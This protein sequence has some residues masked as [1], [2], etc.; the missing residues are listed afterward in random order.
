MNRRMNHF[1]IAFSPI[2][3]WV[4]S[5]FSVCMLSFSIATVCFFVGIA[6][7][8]TTSFC[9]SFSWPLMEFAQLV[10]SKNFVHFFLKNNG[11]NRLRPQSL[12]RPLVKLLILSHPLGASIV[13]PCLSFLLLWALLFVLFLPLP[14]QTKGPILVPTLMLYALLLDNFQLCPARNYWAIS[15][16]YS[17]GLAA[18]NEFHLESAVV[19]T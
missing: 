1:T 11:P 3:S 6:L 12:T 13:F 16:L 15:L 7:T 8:F 14:P 5:S 19:S 9:F 10:L 2:Y 4:V 17:F 18:T